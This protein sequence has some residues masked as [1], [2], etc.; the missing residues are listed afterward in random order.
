MVAALLTLLTLAV[1][2]LALVLHVRNTLQDAAAEG[3]RV[4]ALAG[5]SPQDGVRRTR[6]LIGTAL[7]DGY[8]RHVRYHRG[9]YLDHPAATIVVR[10]PLPVLG[11]LGGGDG[12]EVSGHAGLELTARARR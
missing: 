2:Q 12:L 11:L 4:A 8:A 3:A 5:N 7:G 10:A 1:L 9:S 6:R